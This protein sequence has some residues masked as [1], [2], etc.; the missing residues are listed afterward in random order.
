MIWG[1]I[2][3]TIKFHSFFLFIMLLAFKHT[4]L[5]SALDVFPCIPLHL[6]SSCTFWAFFDKPPCPTTL[7]IVLYPSPWKPPL[8]ASPWAK[9]A[10]P[11]PLRCRPSLTY[12]SSFP[13]K[14]SHKSTYPNSSSMQS[15]PTIPLTSIRFEFLYPWI[16]FPNNGNIPDKI[17]SPTLACFAFFSRFLYFSTIPT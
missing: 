1:F 7:N 5:I 13:T 10:A 8:T 14:L 11:F 9:T 17:T 16:L 3:S 2:S 4:H 6:I 12:I 15:R